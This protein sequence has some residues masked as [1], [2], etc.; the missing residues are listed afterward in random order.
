MFR[1]SWF[2]WGSGLLCRLL[3]FTVPPGNPEGQSLS[4]ECNLVPPGQDRS[5]GNC[6]LPSPVLSFC[7]S[8]PGGV[9]KV[10]T[11]RSHEKIKPK[12]NSAFWWLLQLTISSCWMLHL[13]L[14]Q[15]LFVSTIANSC[16]VPHC[17]KCP[18]NKQKKYQSS[19]TIRFSIK[20][21]FSFKS[22]HFSS[23]F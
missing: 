7:L 13:L 16:Q 15:I 11:P 22:Y 4:A 12:W 18:K 14:S 17:A 10:R 8:R 21:C 1:A 23:Y 9:E 5:D 6:F 3:R 19:F 2:L 20:N